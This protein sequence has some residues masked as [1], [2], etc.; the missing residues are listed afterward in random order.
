VKRT[1]KRGRTTAATNGSTGKG[2]KRVKN[3]YADDLSTPR[4][5]ANADWTPPAGSWEEQIANVDV[6]QDEDGKLIV[7]LNWKNGK[8][9][10]HNTAV[11]YKRC[12]Q[13]VG[14]LGSSAV[15]AVGLTCSDRCFSS[16]N[17]TS[18]SSR[19][20]QARKRSCQLRERSKSRN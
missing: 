1:K 16:M 2:A 18:E 3:D 6:T 4:S 14:S 20:D 11:C 15:Q 10:R 8:K 19:L 12:P 9:T 5:A 17:G 13:K 7:Y